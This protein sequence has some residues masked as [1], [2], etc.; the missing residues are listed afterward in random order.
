MPNPTRTRPNTK[1]APASASPH[2]HRAAKG[3]QS[4][5]AHTA[6]VTF[7]LRRRLTALFTALTALVL[8]TALCITYTMACTQARAAEHALLASTFT[9]LED[10]LRYQIVISDVWLTQQEAAAHS[11]IYI[12]DNGK[13]LHFA[14]VWETRTP[15]DILIALARNLP[16]CAT[17]AANIPG[18]RAE[19]ELTVRRGE[20]YTVRAVRLSREVQNGAAATV[21]LLQ[22][23]A[24][25]RAHARGLLWRYV[26][27]WLC[28]VLV[29]CLISRSLTQLA[30]RPA[31]MAWQRQTEFIAAAG[32]ELRSPLAVIRASLAA[33]QPDTLP[34]QAQ[35]FV[36]AAER[37]AQRMARLTDDL[38]L[39]AAGDAGAWHMQPVALSADT[40]CIELYE[41][42]SA[43]ARASGHML[44]LQLPDDPLPHV[45]ADA[46]YFPQLLSILVQNALD[47]TPKGTRIEICAALSPANGRGLSLGSRP[48]RASVV[49]S[50]RD[51]G[52]GISDADRQSVFER[53]ARADKSRTGRA[54]FGLGLSVAQ[55]IAAL[56][57]TQL[58]LTDTP[59]GGVTFHVGLPKL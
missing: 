52:N 23:D 10:K 38:L 53:F 25:L 26:L 29:L 1:A 9:T 40:L 11:V 8:T 34:S 24:V 44:S 54:H 33:A 51:H 27:L 42:F 45:C 2:A 14:G 18:A 55:E 49:F 58:C 57:D 59:G 12:E 22:D 43:L 48:H 6:Q 16:A 28:G 19:A 30:L 17:V 21:Y 36:L 41:R 3:A 31:V 13:A 15:R 32:H 56:H 4:G 39:L 47:H 20:T 37:E 50:V 5:T 35:S 46:Q 7:A